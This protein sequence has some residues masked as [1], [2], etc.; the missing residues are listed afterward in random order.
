MTR[1]T[2]LH[3]LNCPRENGTEDVPDD[4]VEPSLASQAVNGSF[5]QPLRNGEGWFTEYLGDGR[6][7][8]QWF[9]YNLY[10]NQARLTGVGQVEGNRVVVADMY[11][12]YG[13][14]FG[15]NFVPEDVAVQ[16]WGPLVI[17]FD[18]CDNG[19]ISYS[20]DLPGWGAGVIDVTR[21]TSVSSVACE[22][23]V[24]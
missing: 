22:W 19:Q 7:L 18:D 16:P 21:L 5:Y 15:A 24:P 8:V 11:Y 10:G 1:L 14:E 6:A 3:G 4:S 20:S 2:R 12:V 23:P 17:E 13:T 9:T